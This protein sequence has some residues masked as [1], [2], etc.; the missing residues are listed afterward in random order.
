M[1]KEIPRKSSCVGEVLMHGMFK[2]KYSH[3]IFDNEKARLY[4][5]QLFIEAAG[6]YQIKIMEMGFDNNHVHLLMELGLKSRPEI[7]KKLKGYTAKKFLEAFPEIKKKYFWG[8]GLWNPSYYLESPKNVAGI[9]RYIKNQ[10]YGESP[11]GQKTLQL[12]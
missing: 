12:F 4:C 11:K 9:V 6:I 5:K 7:A 10:K 1:K 3:A 8:S 2:V